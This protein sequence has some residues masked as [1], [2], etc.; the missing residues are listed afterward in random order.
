M[1]Y[2]NKQGKERGGGPGTHVDRGVRGT[3]DAPFTNTSKG[4]QKTMAAPFDQGR[5]GGDNNAMPEEIYADMG[6]PS[7]SATANSRDSLGTIKTDP[8]SARR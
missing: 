2:A 1:A 4:T 3:L 7:K 6:G 8:K 5:T